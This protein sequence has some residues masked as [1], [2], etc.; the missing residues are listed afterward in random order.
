[1]IYEPKEKEVIYLEDVPV[2]DIIPFIDWTYFFHAWGLKCRYPDILR[3][4]D[5]KDEAAT[6]MEDSRNLLDRIVDEK[7]IWAKAVVGIFP[8]NSVDND[9]EVYTDSSRTE[10]R[11]NLHHLRQQQKRTDG[12]P[13]YCLSDFVAPKHTGLKDHI[14]AFA[15]SGGFNADELAAKIKADNR[16]YDAILLQTI[17]DRLAEA[18]AERMHF[19]MRTKYWG[20]A[21][22]EAF[23]NEKFIK[24]KYQGIRPA[25]GY[26]ACP[27]HTE[28]AK[29][30]ELLQPGKLGIEMTESYMMIPAASVCGWFFAHEQS[31][32]F[33]VGKINKDQVEDYARRKGWDIETAERW[34]GPNL[35][36]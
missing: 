18:L 3:H 26:P 12:K 30:W 24:E 4:P 20:Y 36:Y 32:Y 2:K 7:L 23:D 6:L 9:I 15:V 1:M 22:G 5:L 14:G 27:D 33:S 13:N 19:L 10:V 25:P 16:D 28:K 31:K 35:S 17:S 29:L 21:Q 8:A 11:M 34:L